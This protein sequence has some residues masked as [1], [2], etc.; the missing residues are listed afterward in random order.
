MVNVSIIT[1]VYNVERCIHKTINSVINQ[2]S[3]N[4]EL[5]LID[6][7]SKDRS[8]E[9]AK[10][11][12]EKTEIN[13]RV[14]SQENSGVS[15]ARNR[16]ILEAAGEYVCFLDSDDYIHEDYVKLMYEK[17]AKEDC[18]L[19]FCDYTQVTPSGEI[20]VESTTR[21]LESSIDGREA[22]LKQLSCD[23]TIGMGSALYR[24]SI[25]K[26]NNILFDVNRK[27][28]EDVVFTVKA[29]LNMKKVMSVDK[30]LMY[31]VRWDSSITNSVSLKH[32]DCYYSFSDLLEYIRLNGNFEEIEKFLVEYKIPYAISHIF[33]ILSRDRNFH[34]DLFKF[35][36]QDKVRKDLK[37]YRLQRFDKNSIRYLIQCKGIEYCPKMFSKVFARLK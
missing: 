13:Y 9:I 12:L 1:P 33:S 11:L 7:G 24:T 3:K 35:L 29:L 28:A 20:L 36:N 34:E 25:I 37:M 15:A 32:F 21:F 6:D 27:Y 10:D 19:V 23:I 2:S 14:I 26:E 4:F 22:S 17:A 31:Y 18:D 30:A 16:G 5:L 8:I